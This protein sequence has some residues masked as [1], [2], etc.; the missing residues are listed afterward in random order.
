MYI[1][2]NEKIH[3]NFAYVY[4][5]MMSFFGNLRFKK[6]KKNNPEDI[7]DTFIIH[8]LNKKLSTDKEFNP[9]HGHF[10]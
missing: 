1:S 5:F 3:K 2:V 10:F 4:F 7:Y 8:H 6:K 9:K